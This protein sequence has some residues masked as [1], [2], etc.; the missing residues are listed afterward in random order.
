LC[1][2]TAATEY[3]NIKFLIIN[4]L[5]VIGLR[6][7][8]K[9]M[10]TSTINF[11]AQQ[12]LATLKR[13]LP[14][15]APLKDFIFQNT[16]Q[17]FQSFEFFHALGAASEIFGYKTFLSLE[18]FRSLYQK[19]KI[20]SAVLD[21]IIFQRKGEDGVLEWKQKMLSGEYITN[22]QPRIGKLRANWESVYHIDLD[23]RVHPTL[24]R[25]VCSFLDQGISIW[26]FPVWQNGFLLS[27]KEM[28]S[29]SFSSFFKTER[30][31]KLLLDG[32]WQLDYLLSI[33]VG[34]ERYF[35]QYLFDQQFAHPGWSGM[36][37]VIED[38]PETLIDTKKISLEEFIALELILEIDALDYKLGTH[39]QPL[40][41]KLEVAPLDIF[42]EVN[43]GELHE[44]YSLWQEAY[45]WS[46][47]D[48][49]LAGVKMEK[50]EKAPIQQ[51]T[52]Q[53]MFCIDDREISF[54]DYIEKIDPNCETFGTPGF[55]NVEFYFQP[56]LGKSYTKLC[57]APITPKF[58]I[59]EI[60]THRRKK[61]KDYFFG[62]RTHSMFG[63]MIISPIFGFWSAVKLAIG[64]FK[65]S[66]SPATASSF[67]HMDRVSKLTI[68]NT[69]GSHE[70]GLQLGF[71]VSEM[72]DRVE[73]LLKSIHLVKDFAP[74]VYVIGHGASS[75]NNPFYATMDCGACSCRPGSVNA[76]VLCH[77][78]NHVE[79]RKLLIQRGIEIPDTT[80]F[81]GGLHDTTRDEIVFYDEHLLSYPDLK[82]HF[83]ENME[84]FEKALDL[85]AKERS[86]RFESIDTKQDL[87]KIHEQILNRSVSLFEPRPELDHANNALT[88]VGRRSMTKDLFLDRRSFLNSYDYS[89]DPEGVLLTNIMKPI[90]P[91]CGGI[92]LNYYF[93]RVDNQKLG[94]GSKLP[95][96]V[97][98]LFGV[99]NGI[100]GDLRPGL[101]LQMVEAH[102]PI[103]QLVIV[104][105][106]PEV[107]LKVVKSL[108]TYEWFSNNWMHLSA[109]N[110][111]TGEISIFKNGAF[112]PYQPL[113]HGVATIKDMLPIIEESN[114]LENIPVYLI[115]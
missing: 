57:P 97:M 90:A 15:Q 66:M 101:P 76:R 113:Q 29:N 91:V 3:Y 70:N 80:H 5:Y 109:V 55:F 86:R 6:L 81:L 62:K 30:A 115:A 58:L 53:A 94:A 111:S 46:F 20:N 108:P 99:S 73:G 50:S 42:E 41:A 75:V 4:V 59:K 92:N 1:C 65:P 78:A 95:H 45:E 26:N 103:R 28:E 36:V 56:E 52:F 84:V 10:Q 104:E 32:H 83:N 100:D 40:T 35:Q 48:E 112:V 96:N 105:H 8:L 51:K 82:K 19:G 25:M 71:T 79:V 67:K 49:V 68:E 37:G 31:R 54:R 110:P 11:D 27:V 16:L 17:A 63:G 60:G 7:N 74:I 64:V 18:E 14:N 88:I 72:A 12:V 22:V 85:N 38:R 9:N 13:F 93:S 43:T 23:S 114:S 39:W 2:K 69:D 44:I 21:H 33:V 89:S 107:L 102:D 77:M 24:F 61:S 98:G 34:D 87:G 106:F 47:Y